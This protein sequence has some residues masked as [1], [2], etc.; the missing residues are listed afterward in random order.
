L[1]K[2]TFTHD[3]LRERQE[4]SAMEAMAKASLKRSIQ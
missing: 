4:C 2:V 3:K 1:R